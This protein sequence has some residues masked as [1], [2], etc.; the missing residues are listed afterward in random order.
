[1]SEEHPTNRE[2]IIELKGFRELVE[3]RFKNV[4]DHLAKLNGQTAKNTS[5]RQKGAVQL[6]VIAFIG[7]T[8]GAGVITYIINQ[9]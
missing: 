3:E 9:I 7:A 4:N 1:M 2:I 6:S 5:F 8:M